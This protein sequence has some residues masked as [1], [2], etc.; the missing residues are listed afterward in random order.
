[1]A[2]EIEF[3]NVNTN[4]DHVELIW[5]LHNKPTTDIL[6]EGSHKDIHYVSMSPSWNFKVGRR[7]VYIRTLSEPRG[8]KNM[9][10]IVILW[11]RK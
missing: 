2:F 9:N 4:E 11:A 10:A 5:K 7:R 6:W 3:S 8:S 1:M